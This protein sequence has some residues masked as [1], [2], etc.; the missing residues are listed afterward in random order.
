[1]TLPH[2]DPD[3]LARDRHARR[4]AQEEFHRP[5]VLEAGAGTGKTTTL[6]ARVLAWSLGPGWQRAAE[7]RPEATAEATAARVLGGV[8]AITFTEAAAA[9]MAERIGVELGK[10][11]AGDGP[12]SW[13]S[14]EAAG[15]ALPEAERQHRARALAGTLDHLVVR[16]IHA[17]C[18]SILAQFPLEARLHPN[19]EVDADGRLLESIVRETVEEQLQTAYG[20]TDENPFLDLAVEGFGPEELVE[21]TLILA[22]DLPD[23]EAL[24][25][26][27]FAPEAVVAFLAR[28]RTQL[29]TLTEAA[30]PLRDGGAKGKTLLAL[31]ALEALDRLLNRAR[32]A[33]L[34][35][36]E[37]LES[38]ASAARDDCGALLDRVTEWRR[39]KFTVGDAQCLDPAAA[40]R[41]RQSAG[42]ARALLKHLATLQ[43]Q[44]LNTARRAF[45]PLLQQIF[46]T[47]RRRG[48]LTFD[49]LLIEAVNL[50]RDAPE[51]RGRLRRT[52]DQLLVDEFQDTD[53]LQCQL[54]QQLA[55]PDPEDLA[56]ERP[57]L[58]LVGDPKQSIY[59]WRSADL[60]A[61]DGFLDQV[62]HLGG[63]IHPLVEN[64][65]SVPVILDEVERVVRPVMREARGLQ[66]R[67]E[68]LLPCEGRAAETGFQRPPWAAVEYWVSQEQRPQDAPRREAASLAQDLL[69]LHRQEGVAWKDTAVLLRGTGDLDDYLEALRGAGIP[70]AVGRDKQYYRRREIIEAT[71]LV[72]AVLDPGDHLA[73][74]TLLRSP[75]VA[76][77]DAALIPLWSREL[78]A[79]L[80]ELRHPDPDR[81]THLRT[82]VEDAAREVPPEVPGIDGIHGWEL[83]LL[84]AI[85]GLARLRGDFDAEPVDVFVDRLRRF[86]DQEVLSA[87]RY[88]GAF[89]LANLRRFFRQLLAALEEG[90]DTNA[91]L[92]LLRR[93]VAEALEGEEGR[94][95]GAAQ[96]AVSV[97]TIHGAKGLDFQHIYLMQLHKGSNLSGGKATQVGWLHPRPGQPATVEYR[98]LGAPTPGFD[99]LLSQDQAVEAAERVRLLYVAMTR[100]K[101]RLVLAGRW[102][103][104]ASGEDKPPQEADTLLDLVLPGRR[105]AEPVEILAEKADSAETDRCTAEDATWVFLDR[106][107]ATEAAAE[108]AP[109]V[110]LPTTARLAEEALHLGALRQ[111]AEKRMKRGRAAAAS[112]ESHARLARLAATAPEED[113]PDLPG[114]QDAPRRRAMAV[115]SA[116]HRALECF[117][118]DA[119]P[120]TEITHQKARLPAYL[121]PT[122]PPEEIPAAV[123]DAGNLLDHLEGSSL[124]AR[125]VELRDH[126]LAR[127]LPVL[128]P[129]E[130]P[131]GPEGHIA[132]AID[133]VYRDPE[134]GAPVIVDYKTDHLTDDTELEDRAALYAA[135]GKVYQRALQGALGLEEAPRF[136]LWFLGVDRVWV[137]PTFGDNPAQRG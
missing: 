12:P 16:T 44:R 62:R 125:L 119:D 83:N 9:E 1:M 55:L 106:Q 48:I 128:L 59:G 49:A 78:P 118:L 114:S 121:A 100:A 52:I 116:V 98:L 94:P 113:T 131:Q 3:L 37:T 127:E 68:P 96:D 88:L 75:M 13:L 80:S 35:T 32:D 129:P 28:I 104:G 126:I 84:A 120:A 81:L 8:V 26:D 93:S 43:P 46:Q 102:P 6:V 61:Y 70:F 69:R 109:E 86:F 34:E 101:D 124:L 30:N 87:A 111:A 33:D 47:L 41:L 122:L 89:R 7:A 90:G 29:D 112:E 42:E 17:F 110:A 73:L 130:D 51:V 58:F 4:L 99:R 23:P 108:A 39:G 136:E 38:L 19:L 92:R 76:V 36:P 22:R 25:A 10:L 105:P 56:A 5:L 66:P 135:Q 107:E 54:L 85:E 91:L 72:R 20:A 40:E 27:P 115:G 45:L 74:L 57:G 18:R 53:R 2:H 67:F 79:R 60:A 132:G 65:R 31:E 123:R 50:L 14:Q 77:P 82:L 97:L 64:F 103:V 15:G 95:P 11:A 24:E 133:L 21:A 134:T 71:A 117:D 63:E 137:G